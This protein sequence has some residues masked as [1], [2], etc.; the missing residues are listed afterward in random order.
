[1]ILKFDSKAT[2][3]KR[4][5]LLYRPPIRKW[6]KGRMVL[7]GDAAHPMLP[8]ESPRPT[9]ESTHGIKIDHGQG[10][11]QAMED[12]LAIGLVLHGVKKA[13]DIEARL[14]VYEKVRLN[15]AASIQILSNYGVDEAAPE[16]LVDFLEGHPVPSEC[17]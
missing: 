1:M 14:A 17:L 10:G 5:P 11:A 9:Q 4:W 13:A 12:G 2:E 6:Y 16:E 8:R 15:R 3:V 7:V